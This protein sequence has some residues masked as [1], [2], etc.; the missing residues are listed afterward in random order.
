MRRQNQRGITL[1]L[2]LIMLV[3][4][5]IMALSAF[6]IGKASLQVV[7]NAQQQEQVQNASQAMLDQVLSSPNFVSDPTNVLDN[8]NCPSDMSAPANSRCMDLYGDG[9]TV[10]LVQLTPQPT[11]LQ[12][13]GI[14]NSTLNVEDKE[15][16]GC[17]KSPDPNRFGVEGTATDESL[18]SDSL[19]EINAKA[20]ERVS[21]AEAKITQGVNMRVSNDAV[22]TACPTP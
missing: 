15:D 18:C 20:T 5:T 21:R 6:H 13:K 8:S 1:I 17:A 9:K 22:T 7:D 2:S 3:L 10:V 11:C 16:L 14:M 19:W 4:L 12:V